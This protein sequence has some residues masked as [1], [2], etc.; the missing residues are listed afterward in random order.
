MA[1]NLKKEYQS[2]VFDEERVIQRREFCG[3]VLAL[4][5]GCGLCISDV[6]II[7]NEIVNALQYASGTL[8]AKEIAGM[9]ETYKGP[10]S[11]E[12]GRDAP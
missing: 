1:V 2:K 10:C 5:A 3:A 6:K 8:P 11:E 4:V 9:L 7:M 12:Q